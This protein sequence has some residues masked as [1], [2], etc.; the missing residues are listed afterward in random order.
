MFFGIVVMLVVC[1]GIP[2]VYSWRMGRMDVPTKPV[3]AILAAD[4]VLFVTLVGWLMGY[5]RILHTLHAHRRFHCDFALVAKAARI[6]TLESGG[7]GCVP[8]TLVLHD[9]GRAFRRRSLLRRFRPVAH[10]NQEN[11]AFRWRA[12]G[13]WSAK[14]E[15]LVSSTIMQDI[16]R[17]TTPLISRRL[18]ALGFARRV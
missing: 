2:L 1:I 18:T 6:T 12:V 7:A 14:R 4:A 3:W 15:A 16:Q 8:P 10:K 9:L 5:R 11:S 17:S 13:S